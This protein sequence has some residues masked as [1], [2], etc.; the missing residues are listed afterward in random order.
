VFA[1]L[2][3]LAPHECAYSAEATS[4]LI[5]ISVADPAGPRRLDGVLTKP[6]TA[7]Q[8]FPLVILLSGSGMH[9]R[10]ASAFGHRFFRDL[11]GELSRN[12]VATFRFDFRGFGSSTGSPDSTTLEF[13]EDAEAVLTH[14]R[15]QSS[16]SWLSI[17][18]LG[19]SE[20]GAMAGL[21]LQRNAPVDFVV[22]V[23]TAMTPLGPVL[24]QQNFDRQIE[25][26]L[27]PARAANNKAIL[28]DWIR[29]VLEAKRAGLDPRAALTEEVERV[30]A[31]AGEGEAWA[32]SHIR[33]LSNRW[34]L[35]ALDFD[36][37]P[38]FATTAVPLLAVFGS[39]DRQVK[40]DTHFSLMQGPASRNPNISPIVIPDMNHVM[41][42]PS[43]GAVASYSNPDARVSGEF[44]RK[45]SVFVSSKSRQKSA[46]GKQLDRRALPTS[47]SH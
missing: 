34:M 9:D 36:P 44:V 45:V 3:L 22:L 18:V 4:E 17:G 46:S 7:A 20:G 26:G 5:S 24:V 2:H 12:G 47:C 10:D 16:D 8:A 42:A 35:F 19:H 33:L 40:A 14:F 32:Q 31:S 1:I 41:Q 30:R 21:L 15:H 37:L 23:N 11:A 27:G 39:Q 43:D 25:L 29:S 38:I 28:D 13:S 6:S